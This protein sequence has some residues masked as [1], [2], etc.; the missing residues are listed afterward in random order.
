MSFSTANVPVVY[1]QGVIV[2]DDALTVE[3]LDGRSI[4]APLAWYR[5]FCTAHPENELTG[6]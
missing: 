3:L 4:S 1:A 6:V 5:A 2:T